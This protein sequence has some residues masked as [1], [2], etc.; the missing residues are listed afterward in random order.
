M[1]EKE[2]EKMIKILSLSKNPRTTDSIDRHLSCNERDI[3][4]RWGRGINGN[5]PDCIERGCQS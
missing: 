4:R 3:K 5:R 1:R 2:R